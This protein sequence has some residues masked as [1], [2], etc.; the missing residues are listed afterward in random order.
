MKPSS[1]IIIV[2]CILAL[3]A[4]QN[5][6][7]FT[8]CQSKNKSA[9]V[10]TSPKTPAIDP[11]KLNDTITIL[12]VGDVMMGT[13]Y[14]AP[15]FMPPNDGRNLFDNVKD[16]I[17]NADIKFMNL[18]GTLFDAGGTPKSCGN[19]A[20]CYSFRMPS[21]L[22]KNITDAGFN[23]ISIANNHVGDF[24]DGGRKQTVDNLNALGLL[25]AG[26]VN[27]P[28]TIIEAKGL[29]LGM[30]AVA[31]NNNCVKLNDYAGIKNYIAQLK[32]TCQLVMVSFHGGA[33]GR[34]KQ[35]VPKRH[36]IFYGEDRGNVYEMAHMAIDAG[37]DMV[38][39]H[40]PHVTRAIEIYKGKPITYSLGNFC[41]WDRI[42]L[43]GVSGV[44]PIFKIWMTGAGQFIK[45][46]IVSTKQIGKGI[47][48]IDE[49]KQALKIIQ[50]LTKAD[51]PNAPLTIS[52]NGVVMAK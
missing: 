36:E 26:Q 4:W 1:L 23:L 3:T 35:H 5:F 34:D 42:S 17:K 24:G 40:G 52:D 25:Y 51:F 37:A 9:P 19:P 44:A 48:V 39:G 8:S 6:F 2:W 45:A 38:I 28:T 27:Y 7:P 32:Q 49:Y 33:E 50:Q 12:A 30:V 41:T 10:S 47:P 31:P 20:A 43:A 22:G 29:K 11:A 16:V 18:E 14:P 21:K 46:E 13:N 15:G